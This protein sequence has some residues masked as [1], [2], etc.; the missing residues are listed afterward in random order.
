MK[1][2]TSLDG[3]TAAL[4]TT[5]IRR[6]REALDVDGVALL[7]G[8]VAVDV[9]DGLRTAVQS[10]RDAGRPMSRQVLYTHR[11]RPS[12]RPPLTALMDQWLSPH[13]FDGLARRATS[14]TRCD[15]SL[16][17]SWVRSRCSSKTCSW[18]SARA[19]RRSPGTRTS[20][21]GPSIGRWAWC[22]GSRSRRPTARP[23]PLRSP[24]V[25]T[26]SGRGPSLICTTGRPA[27]A[28][29][30]P[31]L[32][33]GRMAVLRA[34]LPG[35][36]RR[37][38]HA[39][40]VPR[41]AR[42]APTGER[43]AWSCIFL[44]PRARWRHANAPNHPLC[45][46]VPTARPSRSSPMSELTA[47]QRALFDEQGHLVVGPTSCRTTRSRACGAPSRRRPPPGPPRST[48]RSTTTS[49]SSRSGRT[50]GSTTPRSA[51]SCH[52]Q[53]AAAIAAELIGCEQGARVPRPP[54][55]EAAPRRCDHPLAPRSAQ[56]ARRRAAGRVLLA[57]ARRRDRRVRRHA[58]HARRPQ[59]ADDALH[60]LPERGEGMGRPGEGRRAGRRARRVAIFHHCLS[61][62]TSPP[63]RTGR[64]ATRLH[65]DLPRRDLHLTTPRGPAGTLCPAA[66]PCR[67]AQSSTRTPS[68][69]SAAAGVRREPHPDVCE[70]DAPQARAA[71]RGGGGARPHPAGERGQVVAW[72]S[73]LD[74][75]EQERARLHA[76]PT[77]RPRA[78]LRSRRCAVHARR[79]AHRAGPASAGPRRGAGGLQG[80]DHQ[81]QGAPRPHGPRRV[82][83]EQQGP[84][85]PRVRATSAS[86]SPTGTARRW[87]TTRW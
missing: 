38:V 4:A 9:L 46:L 44:S 37:G 32:R 48:R 57:G 59:G 53:R 82:R 71:S 47:A 65:H 40:H 43:A 50:C 56:L 19:R 45:K 12:D 10:N 27:G 21:T 16:P 13:R 55:R 75:D 25:A 77:R 79:G 73:M 86:P 24:R 81:R 36:R 18:S 35:R 87:A 68:R 69:P 20:G 31:R 5:L 76:L 74:A 28:G 2:T 62:H 41:V 85:G 7:R 34:D 58:L 22:C 72:W 30:G 23:G 66:S 84:V 83:V 26:A 33:R 49:R 52:H 11:R 78:G 3:S 61:W 42:D 64:L 67:R 17:S 39:D 15:P 70:L 29:R 14:P 80:R 8:V 60:R 6:A 54:D 51:S 1:T 63:N